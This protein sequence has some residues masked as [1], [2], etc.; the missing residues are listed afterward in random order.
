MPPMS[1]AVP[2]PLVAPIRMRRVPSLANSR[3]HTGGRVRH[4]WPL[5]ALVVTGLMLTVALKAAWAKP[6][7]ERSIVRNRSAFAQWTVAGAATTT[8][9]DIIAVERAVSA[10]ASSGAEP[11]VLVT[12]N[13]TDNATGE[14]LFQAFGETSQFVLQVNGNLSS[15]RLSAALGLFDFISGTTEPFTVNLTFT[16]VGEVLEEKNHFTSNEGG[17]VINVF[18]DVL[19]RP[20]SAAGTVSGMG[21]N[22]TPVP[23]V[24]AF[25]QKI[26]S[27]TV[28]VTKE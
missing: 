8:F 10:T 2:G 3:W 11:F 7:F 28:I 21:I 9:V 12:V 15:A 14:F 26:H 27:G 25:I 16:G 5:I 20:A 18:G 6:L 4:A 17:V 19:E 1:R 13:Q 23:T 22:F 24:H